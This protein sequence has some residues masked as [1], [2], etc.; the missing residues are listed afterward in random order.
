MT[1]NH[2]L[3]EAQFFLAREHKKIDLANSAYKTPLNP[4]LF[5]SCVERDDTTLGGE[6]LHLKS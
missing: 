5:G 3:I 4:S 2:V 1:S 6:Y